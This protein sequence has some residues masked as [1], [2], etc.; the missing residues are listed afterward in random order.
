MSLIETLT[1]NN[2]RI[3]TLLSGKCKLGLKILSILMVP[4]EFHKIIFTTLIFD[5]TP[6]PWLSK[7]ILLEVPSFFLIYGSS[8]IGLV[9]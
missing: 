8:W 6:D 9:F 2:C 5:Q 4:T 1:A 7:Y 3:V